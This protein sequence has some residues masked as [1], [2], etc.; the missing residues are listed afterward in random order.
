MTTQTEQDLNAK[1]LATLN[2]MIPTWARAL[3]SVYDR[4][5]APLNRAIDYVFSTGTRL[6]VSK[7]D[8]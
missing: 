3:N 2:Q 5:F 8:K 1:D 6:F 7:L 4:T